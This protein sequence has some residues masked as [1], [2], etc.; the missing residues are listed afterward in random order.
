VSQRNYDTAFLFVTG[1]IQSGLDEAQKAANGKNIR[2]R[3]GVSTIRQF[4]QAGY[5]DEMQLTFSP[6]FR[7]S[8]E[9]LVSGIDMSALGFNRIEKINGEK[10]IHI[11]LTKK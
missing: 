9:H 2:I 3:V 10:A 1:G 6:V 11:I 8:G 4:L 5:I 7:G